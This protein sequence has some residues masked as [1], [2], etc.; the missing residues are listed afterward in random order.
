[1]KKIITVLCLAIVCMCIFY[2][3]TEDNARG[4][5]V[6]VNPRSVESFEPVETLK[7]DPLPD[8][9]NGLWEC[10]YSKA[11]Y[12]KIGETIEVK[13]IDNAVVYKNLG[14]GKPYIC[15]RWFCFNKASQTIDIFNE[16]PPFVKKYVR[17]SFVVK[18][19]TQSELILSRKSVG[20]EVQFKKI[21]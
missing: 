18:K 9:W 14:G 5:V 19:Q 10:V 11:N 21:K 8:S 15:N 3:C 2:G 16:Q 17:D 4:S 13:D 6:Q 12:F 1:M 7:S 20:Q